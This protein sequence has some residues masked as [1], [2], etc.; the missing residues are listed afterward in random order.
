MPSQCLDDRDVLESPAPHT[1]SRGSL[2]SGEEDDTLSTRFAQKRPEGGREEGGREG[3]RERGKEVGRGGGREGG[4][5]VGRE[6]V[7]HRVDQKCT[8]EKL[9]TSAQALSLHLC[10]TLGTKVENL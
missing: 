1:I 8:L 4:G 10:E 9:F 7:P 6:G 2:D 5:E 3:G